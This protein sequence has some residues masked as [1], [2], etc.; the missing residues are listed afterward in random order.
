MLWNSE[1]VQGFQSDLHFLQA[2]LGKDEPE[3]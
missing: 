3:L 1:P 2:Y